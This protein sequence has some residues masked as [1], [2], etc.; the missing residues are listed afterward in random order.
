MKKRLAAVCLVAALCL[1]GCTLGN[2][3]ATNGTEGKNKITYKNKIY[4]NDKKDENNKT[5]LALSV[6]YPVFESAIDK[7]KTEKINN[8]IKYRAEEFAQ[9]TAELYSY[10]LDSEEGHEM[11][12]TNPYR[13]DYIVTVKRCD[14]KVISLETTISQYTGGAHSMQSYKGLTLDYN[15]GE[16]ISLK[17]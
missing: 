14:K 15:T 3:R 8:L 5:L 13:A 6:S 7:D 9:N 17:I 1:T 16:E 2:K 10:M 12:M 4:N 11:E